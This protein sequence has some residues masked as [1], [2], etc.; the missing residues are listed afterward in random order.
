[1]TANRF[2]RFCETA[3]SGAGLDTDFPSL[4]DLYLRYSDRRDE[5]LGEIDQDDE[6]AFSAWYHDPHRFGGHPWEIYR[7]GL[8]V[9]VILRVEEEGGRYYLSLAGNVNCYAK[10]LAGMFL[11]L[12]KD[13]APVVFGSL[14]ELVRR[15]KG[16]DVIGIL[17][18]HAL[19][20][21]DY[22]DFFEEDV[23][24]YMYAGELAPSGALREAALMPP[25]TAY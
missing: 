16:K 15:L 19:S 8:D 24:E 6:E 17:P 14:A 1:M 21:R 13:S 7:G 3:Y 22:E 9:G 2:Y 23:M 25:E 18:D 20:E 4:R 11:A 5:G 12:R 10:M